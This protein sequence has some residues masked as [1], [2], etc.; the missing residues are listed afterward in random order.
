LNI[1]E[2]EYFFLAVDAHFIC[3]VHLHGTQKG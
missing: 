2:R 3:N 1:D